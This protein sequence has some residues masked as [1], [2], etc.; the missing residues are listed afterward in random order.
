MKN[1]E[2]E[3]HGSTKCTPARRFIRVGF[4]ADMAYYGIAGGTTRYTGELAKALRECPDVE[5]R[6]VS[7][8]SEA[9]VG[10]IAEQRGYPRARSA[11]GATPRSLRMLLWQS[12]WQLIPLVSDVD[13]LHTPTMLVPPSRNVPL[14]VTVHDM[15]AWLFPDLHTRRT[16]WLTRLAFRAAKRRGA[17]FLADSASTASDL[18][19]IGQLSS[20]RIAVVP[21]AAD[22]RFGPVEDSSVPARFGLDEPYMLYVGTL[23]P[24]KGIDTLLSAFAA[25]GEVNVRLAIAG[26]QG[27]M[28]EALDERVTALGLASRVTFTG[29]VPDED[30]PALISGALVFVYPSLYEGFGL[31]VLEAMQCG[32]PVITS[33]VSSLPE[34][35]GDAALMVRPR[36]VAGFAAA[37]RRVLRDAGL[38]EEL[39]ERGIAQAAKF[40]WKRTAELTVEA[41]HR[42]LA[43]Q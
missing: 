23:E 14:V 35:A 15:T 27:W 38:R 3:H 26:K 12:G 32:V 7:L 42:A 33:E 8:Y 24:R 25:L 29:F 4:W 16:A 22:E 2:G 30:L 43:R 1:A 10:A 5:L 41:Y 39:R 37:M 34:V 11:G 19:R 40:S 28:F 20:D 21:L 17:F 6:L 18:M 13:V 31:P 9:H 36:D